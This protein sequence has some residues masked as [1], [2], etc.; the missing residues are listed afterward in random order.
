MGKAKRALTYGATFG[1]GFR[2]ANLL[3]DTLHTTMIAK[4]FKPFIDSTRGLVKAWKE[5]ENYVKLMASGAGFGSSYIRA[6]DPQE[7]AKYI[8]RILKKEGKGNRNFILDTPRRVLDFWEKVGSVSENAARVQLYTNLTKKGASHFEAAFEAR[9]LLDFTMRGDAG[10][11]RF[12]TQVTPFLNAR[13]QGLYRLGRGAVHEKTRKMFLLRGSLLTLASMALW[14]SNKDK[15]E[16]KELEDWDKWSYYHF[17]VGKYHFRLPKPFEVGAIF[18]SFPETLMDALSGNEEGKHVANFMGYTAKETFAIGAP[19][20]F[21]PIIEQWANKSAFTG[22]P[23][24]GGALK[25]LKPS[26]QKEPWTSETMQLAGKFGISP[27]RAEALVNGYFATLGMFILGMTDVLVHNVLDFPEDPDARIDDMPAIGRFVKKKE[28]ARYTK[29][30]SWFYDMFKDVDEI[31]KT[32]NHYARTGELV[33]AKAFV[34]KHQGKLKYR[35]LLTQVKKRVSD[36]NK[37]IK[38]I[39]ISKTL[40]SD[41]KVEKMEALLKE[42]NRLLKVTYGKIMGNIK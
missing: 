32:V 33:K 34:K 40:A 11:V 41:V 6:D 23:I 26:E 27:K 21:Q 9:D 38:H 17:W 1:P 22:R 29:Y 19:Q 24:V 18:S 12:L 39:M 16:Y 2:I 7:A 3:R 15:D 8:D 5:D 20:L 37:E 31:L 35:P 4:S 10:I 13:M 14:Y 25:G 28:P 42:K 36:I 30:Q